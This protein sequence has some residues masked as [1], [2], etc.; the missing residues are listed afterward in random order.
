LD[1]IYEGGKVILTHPLYFPLSNFREGEQLNK[2]TFASPFS[3]LL[4][5]F[6]FPLSNRVRE[7]EQWFEMFFASPLSFSKERGR[8]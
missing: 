8:G 3:F 5:P 1:I 2:T 4:T 7:G 6:L